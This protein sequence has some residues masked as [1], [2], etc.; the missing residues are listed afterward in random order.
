[1]TRIF[2]S[3]L[4][5]VPLILIFMNIKKLTK[6]FFFIVLCQAAGFIGTFFTAGGL[7]PW[8]N[9]I[10]KPTFNPPGWIF[11]PVWVTLYAL[12]GIALY[13]IWQKRHSLLKKKSA[14]HASNLFL[15]NLGLNAIWSPI[16]FGAHNIELALI[17]IIL[18]WF[19]LAFSIKLYAQLSRP[20]AWLLMPYLFW[21][22]F[23]TILNISIFALN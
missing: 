16:F 12:M 7:D 17:T 15:V 9:T 23:A 22:T 21:T 8:Y 13:I 10:I 19:T 1:L 5:K 6:A 18:I 20:A 3:G 11:G 14:R 2:K 4:M